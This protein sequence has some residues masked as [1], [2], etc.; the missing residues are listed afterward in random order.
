MIQRPRPEVFGFFSDAHNL[1]LITPGFLRFR[2]LTP[3]KIVMG[4]GTHIDYELRLYGLP[5]R[6][7]TVIEEFTPEAS[8][9]DVQQ[10]GPYRTWR[11]RHT[12]IEVAGGTEMH[13]HVD[14]EMPFGPLGAVARVLFVRRA[15]ARIFDHRNEAIRSLFRQKA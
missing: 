14:Y 8:F 11:H 4:V 7:R 5:V 10:S 2:I 6:W 13:D 9:V 3:G 15:L 12:F 1:E